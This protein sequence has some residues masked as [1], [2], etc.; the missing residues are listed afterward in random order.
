VDFQGESI[1]AA[2][3]QIYTGMDIGTAKATM[4]ER[5]QVPHH[6]IDI[7]H[8]DESFTVANF[9]EKTKE[10]IT[11][12]NKKDRLPM[13]VG[14]TGLY[15]QS[16][17]YTYHFSDAGE[18]PLYREK[19][20]QLAL[21]EGNNV[22]HSHL[23][24]VDP[25]TAQRLHP[26]DIKR[27]IRA[28]EIHHLT[29]ETMVQFQKRSQQSPY[30][31][32]LLGL[33]M[34]RSLLYERINQRVDR[35]VQE[36]LIEEVEQ[37]LARGYNCNYRSMQALGYKEMV[38]YLQGEMNKE[39]AIELIKKRTRNFAKR[40][41]TWFRNMKDVVWFDLTPGYEDPEDQYLRIY[42]LVAGKFRQAT[43]I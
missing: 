38:A 33:N 37:L 40:Q 1:S 17:L 32:L 24:Q 15:I 42:Q 29:G 11:D 4:E 36:G 43:N 34:E 19:M 39:E 25:L 2:S 6:L 16:V 27:V 41:L 8:P 13:I 23:A 30:D 35:M 21:K 3:I 26:N 20:E 5:A 7:C 31:L 10:L 28:L 12:I 9:Q 22:L 14:G 18:D